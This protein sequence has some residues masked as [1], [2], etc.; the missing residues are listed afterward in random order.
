M[1]AFQTGQTVRV[2]RLGAYHSAEVVRA[3]EFSD[4]YTVFMWSIH[5][6]LPGHVL[7]QWNGDWN[8]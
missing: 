6:I 5:I 2:W 1:R 7:R 8:V 3:D 4:V